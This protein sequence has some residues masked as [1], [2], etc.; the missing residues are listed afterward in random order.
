MNLSLQGKTTLIQHLA[1][2][3]GFS[4]YKLNAASLWTE[5]RGQLDHYLQKIVKMLSRDTIC[6]C[7]KLLHPSDQKK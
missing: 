7:G 3:Y 6:K 1:E 2:I 5:G 4:Y